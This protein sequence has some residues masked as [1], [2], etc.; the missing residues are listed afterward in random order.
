MLI[1]ST[2]QQNTMPS[3][4]HNAQCMCMGKKPNLNILI[5]VAWPQI[6]YISDLGAHM[7]V[8]KIWFEKIRSVVNF[9]ICGK[10][11]DVFT[12]I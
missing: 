8:T 2:N 10:Y 12:E 4:D 11:I 5:H 1:D 6:R 9:E 3:D 7:N